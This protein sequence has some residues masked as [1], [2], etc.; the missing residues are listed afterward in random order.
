MFVIRQIQKEAFSESHTAKFAIE[1]KDALRIVI[2]KN[3][4]Q[5]SDLQLLEILQEL[6]RE[7]QKLDI[8]KKSNVHRLAYL[9]FTFPQAMKM[10]FSHQIKEELTYPGRSEDERSMYLFLNIVSNKIN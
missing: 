7:C 2:P 8:R 6:I 10:P 3:I 1:L 4:E 9:T 5:F